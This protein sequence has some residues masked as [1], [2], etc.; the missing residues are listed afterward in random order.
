MKG[1]IALIAA[2]GLLP[3]VY[4]DVAP[5]RSF[6][7][8]PPRFVEVTEHVVCP[9]GESFNIVTELKNGSLSVIALNSDKITA[10]RSEL[11]TLSSWLAAPKKGVQHAVS[12][13]RPSGLAVSVWGFSAEGK[14][15]YLV[16]GWD[17][18]KPELLSSLR[19]PLPA[20]GE[21]R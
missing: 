6:E 14:K 19:Y 17:K 21:A 5:P 20:A 7:A 9:N 11:A 4:A 12:C 1:L 15:L 3:P 2:A 13:R 10:T 16:A 18:G 8:D